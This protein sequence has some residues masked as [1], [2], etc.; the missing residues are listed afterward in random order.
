MKV[1]VFFILILVSLNSFSEEYIC[2]SD[3]SQIGREGEVEIMTYERVGDSFKSTSKYGDNYF[4]VLK[5]TEEF[6]FLTRTFSYPDIRI[7]LLHKKTKEVFD[8]YFQIT[9]TPSPPMV[10]KCLIKK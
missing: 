2:S 5:E 10:G 7:V 1:T 6:I 9:E 8:S 4:Q 3:L